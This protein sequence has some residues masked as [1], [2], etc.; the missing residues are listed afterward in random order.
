VT[1][2]GIYLLLP[3]WSLTLPSSSYRPRNPYT[4]VFALTNSG[5]FPASSVNVQCLLRSIHYLNP[6]N[7]HSSGLISEVSGLGRIDRNES[8][9]FN[10]PQSVFHPEVFHG[11]LTPDQVKNL[12]EDRKKDFDSNGTY[13][14]PDTPFDSADFEVHVV[15][16]PLFMPFHWTSRFRVI[17]RPSQDGSSVIWEQVDLKK[18]F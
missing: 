10:C 3:S 7:S 12:Y 2:G 1:V 17:A 11:V 13:V 8:R 18:K 16:S 14:G 4:A 5:S 6:Q 9:T 15:Y